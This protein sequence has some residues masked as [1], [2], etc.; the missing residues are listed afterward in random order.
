MQN[1]G[2]INTY[3]TWKFKRLNDRIARSR[4]G[5]P[6]LHTHSPSGERNDQTIKS[7]IL[8]IVTDSALD[9]PG[10]MWSTKE[11]K[12]ARK[13]LKDNDKG[14]I[15]IVNK[16]ALSVRWM[17]VLKLYHYLFFPL[18][19]RR[20]DWAS[21]VLTWAEHLHGWPASMSEEIVTCFSG[22]IRSP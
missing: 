16:Q 3:S 18:C 6:C 21:S 17:N 5:T 10:N 7:D 1:K 22:V 11:V 8:R 14:R 2:Q 12:R 20:V 19:S 15:R 13:F 9:S 4:H